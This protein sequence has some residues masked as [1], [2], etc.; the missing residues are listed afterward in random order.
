M[1]ICVHLFGSRCPGQQGLRELQC[2][3]A[4]S[5]ALKLIAVAMF[6]FMFMCIMIVSSICVIVIDMMISIV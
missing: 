5:A 6:V 4:A 2:F 1:Y 3:A